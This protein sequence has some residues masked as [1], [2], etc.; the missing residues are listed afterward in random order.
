M[1]TPPHNQITIRQQFD[2]REPRPTTWGRD[3]FI[4]QADKV[5]SQ[6]LGFRYLRWW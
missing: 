6:K 5:Y 2:N 1:D 4:H 3:A